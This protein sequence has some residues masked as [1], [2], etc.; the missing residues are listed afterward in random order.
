[1]FFES[2][3]QA[4][5]GRNAT[6]NGNMSAAIGPIADASASNDDR[7]LAMRAAKLLA[8]AGSVDIAALRKD[9]VFGIVPSPRRGVPGRSGCGKSG[10]ALHQAA[11][12][13]GERA[14]GLVGRAGLLRLVGDDAY[15]TGED[16]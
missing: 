14:P 6:R 4:R 1:M 16:R 7:N 9:R 5:I 15:R 10:S 11:A 8:A 3:T 12:A 13:L 2:P